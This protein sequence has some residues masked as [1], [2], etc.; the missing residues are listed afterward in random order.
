MPPTPP[1]FDLG[2][3]LTNALR[4]LQQGPVPSAAATGQS[5]SGKTAGESQARPAE[6][7][8]FEK[9]L[10]AALNAGHEGQVRPRGTYVN[11]SI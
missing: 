8:V 1:Q 4:A 7:T 2:R 10:K 6:S 5:A 11:L 3:S 9:R